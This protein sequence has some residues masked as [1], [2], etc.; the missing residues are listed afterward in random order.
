MKISIILPVLNEETVLESCLNPLQP[1]RRRGHEVIVVDGGS[2]DRTPEI[3]SRLAD[4]LLVSEPGRATQMNLGA[5]N[6]SGDIFLFLHADTIV[7]SEIDSILM[8][9]VDEHMNWG[10]FDI[11]L[12]GEAVIFRI[13]ERL[14]NFRSWASGIATGDQGIFICA[15]LYELVDGYPEIPLMEDIAICHQ[16]IKHAKPIC[17]RQTI[18]TS[19]RRWE[20]KGIFRTILLMWILRL[21][22]YLG[23]DPE[24]L[25]KSYD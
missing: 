13:I 10:R 17:I 3:S 15:D 23:A 5:H 12:S 6:A 7:S 20:E 9:N 25:A 4:K 2:V 11:R 1:L 22:Y 8:K 21:Q 24:T 16:L 19:S 18:L 14:I